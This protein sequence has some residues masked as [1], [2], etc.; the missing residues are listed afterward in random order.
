MADYPTP[1]SFTPP[2]APSPVQPT[3][4]PR[5]WPTTIGVISIVLGS[6]G[7]IGGCWGVVSPTFMGALSEQMPQGSIQGAETMAKH[8]G[9]YAVSGGAGMMVATLLLIAGIG[10]LR[11][12]PWSVSANRWWA[13]LKMLLVVG[14]VA[15][16]I[17]IQDEVVA[18]ITRN[19][20]NAA[21]MGAGFVSVAVGIGFAFVLLWGW[22]YPVFLLIWLS[23]R[24]VKAETASWQRGDDQPPVARPM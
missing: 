23:R 12:R 8:A 24:G 13:V 6:L 16:A 17:L 19:D 1:P 5:V 10:M 11:R 21:A 7:I 15:F 14:Q 9:M 2:T 20:P 18:E 3:E 4:R 22:A